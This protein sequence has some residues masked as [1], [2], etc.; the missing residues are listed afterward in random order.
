M[1]KEIEK[2]A[3]SRGHN[4]GLII[5][6]NNIDDLNPEKLAGIDVAI[7]FSRPDSAFQNYMKCFE[8]KVPVVSG[9]TGWL[10]KKSRNNFV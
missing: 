1:G 6:V 4:I 7:E 10:D 8:A 2:I 9:T 5:D 3:V